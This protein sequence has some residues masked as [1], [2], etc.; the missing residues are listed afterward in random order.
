[1]LVHHF[2]YT[3]LKHITIC[4][5][6]SA[7]PS[8]VRANSTG[9]TSILVRWGGVPVVDQNGVILGYAV[10]YKALP[11]SGPQTKLVSAPTT[12]A[13]LTGLKNYTN[14]SI[15]VLAFTVK[16]DGP[17]SVPIVVIIDEDSEFFSALTFDE[18]L[19][20]LLSFLAKVEAELL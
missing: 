11:D 2:L 5:E 1:M 15:T 8:D 18:K 19:H 17:A 9:T 13:T 6:P 7:P 14:Y 3:V 20:L 4:T 10:T 16:G 12:Q